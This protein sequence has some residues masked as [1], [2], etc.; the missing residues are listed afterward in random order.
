M[1]FSCRMNLGNCLLVRF[2]L[3]IAVEGLCICVVST[4][5]TLRLHAHLLAEVCNL[6]VFGADPIL[7]LPFAGFTGVDSDREVD[8]HDLKT[9]KISTF[10]LFIASTVL[11]ALWVVS[12]NS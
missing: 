12:S 5:K 3:E 2:G 11:S 10:I 9:S 8:Y 4:L 1:R 7:V 6:A